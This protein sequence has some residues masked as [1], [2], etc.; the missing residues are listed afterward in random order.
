VDLLGSFSDPS[1]ILLGTF[2]EPSLNL[3]VR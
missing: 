3:A 2:S 1:R